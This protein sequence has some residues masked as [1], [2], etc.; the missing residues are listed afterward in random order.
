MTNNLK[1]FISSIA[2]LAIAS[3]VAVAPVSA[4]DFSDVA[5]TAEYKQAIDELYALGIMNGYEDGTI[6]P[7][8]N[9]TRAEVTKLV[10]ATMGPSYTEAAVGATGV[11]TQF[12]D[13]PGSHWASGYIATGV[14]NSFINGMGDGTFAPEENVTYAQIVKMITAAMGYTSICERNGGY[15]NGYLTTAASIG[16][17]KGVNIVGADT[18]VTRGQVAMLLDNALNI[19]IVG[20]TGYEEDATTGKLIAKTDIMDEISQYGDAKDYKTLLTENH[21]AFKVKGRVTA[22]KKSDSSLDADE[23]KFKVEA[24]KNFDGYAYGQTYYAATNY[25]MKYDGTDA[26]DLMFTYAEALVQKD[27]DE[28]YILLSVTPYGANKTEVVAASLYDASSFDGRQ[29][30]FYADANSSK[31]NTY[32]LNLDTNNATDIDV[33]VNGVEVAE[34][35][36]TATS[37]AYTVADIINDYIAGNDAGNVTLIDATEE[38]K[39]TTDGKIDYILVNYYV[40]AVV[41]SISEGETYRV[42]FSDMNSKVRNMRIDTTDEDISATFTLDGAAIEYTDLQKGDVLSIAY[43][44]N[45]SFADSEFYDAIVSRNTVSGKVSATGEDSNN[46]EYFVINGENYSAAA[47]M[48]GSVNAEDLNPGT[49]YILYLNAFGKFVSYDE[50]STNKLIGIFDQASV[51]SSDTPK[52]RIITSAGAKVSYPVKDNS[53]SKYNQLAAFG[54]V[55]GTV[56]SATSVYAPT[57]AK[58]PLAERIVE[59]TVNSSG[60]ITNIKPLA[61]KL[62]NTG[63]EVSTGDVLTQSGEYKAASNKIN[64]LSFSETTVVIDLTSTEN[65]ADFS[66]INKVSAWTTADFTDGENYTVLATDRANSDGTYRFVLVTVGASAYNGNTAIAVYKS[67]G[68]VYDEEEGATVTT[69]NAYTNGVGENDDETTA[70]KVASDYTAPAL[71][72]GDVF[73]YDT[74]ADGYVN[75]IIPVFTGV[76]RTGYQ[77]FVAS[78]KDVAATGIAGSVSAQGGSATKMD[79]AAL[80]NMPAEWIAT[81]NTS[82]AGN[83]EVLFGVI[84]D[85]KSNYASVAQI[86]GGATVDKNAAVDYT[87]AN[88]AKVCVYDYSEAKETNRLSL[89]SASS[90][91][92]SP[93]PES[94]EHK[95][96]NGNATGV[97]DILDTTVTPNE[98]REMNFVFAKLVD[99]DIAEALVIVGSND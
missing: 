69:I 52:I 31:T 72:V 81:D 79:W 43:D 56:G 34:R 2:A 21:E 30:E 62:D 41:D 7:E 26:A 22:T 36:A 74:D 6:K 4:A 91:I 19:P 85:K 67:N 94:V 96:S 83:V 93:V 86:A 20:I 99:G 92:K 58:R 40:D 44:V 95:D 65:N 28:N 39:T 12:T 78:V 17:T 27:T 24:T 53:K 35:A 90:L 48:Y 87:I 75:E 1:K 8:N 42:Y 3:S 88:D 33:Y 61:W 37:S 70:I 13:V 49:E 11:D 97:F 16:V 15:P 47:S 23:I 82:K 89:G 73:V 10:V 84:T 60:Y 98:Y 45:K 51:D 54:Y 25:T 29:M 32:K 63:A 50:D 76:N 80:T 57:T 71:N 77:A 5:D 18:V 66:D 14:A 68:S 55:A 9:I 38:G 64:N 46:V 59:Y